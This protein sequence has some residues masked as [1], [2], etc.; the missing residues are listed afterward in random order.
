MQGL[1][2]RLIKGKMNDKT[3]IH[4]YLHVLI[5]RLIK[6]K[7]AIGLPFFI[8]QLKINTE[9]VESFMLY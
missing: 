8:I 2:K 5:K 1:I 9:L 4:A 3:V 6:K 7:G